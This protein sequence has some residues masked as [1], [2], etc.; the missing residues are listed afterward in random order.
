MMITPEEAGGKWKR[1]NFSFIKEKKF[2]EVFY[3]AALELPYQ[4][5]I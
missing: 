4:N 5:T 1:G 2:Y 3:A